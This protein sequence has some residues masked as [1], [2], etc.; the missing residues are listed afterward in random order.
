MEWDD[1]STN[2]IGY[3]SQIL[4]EFPTT[5][6]GQKAYLKWLVTTIKS[7]P[8]QK[9]IGFCYWAPDCVAFND[10]GDTSTNGSAWENQCMFEFNHKV[11]PIFDIFRHH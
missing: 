2:F 4:G 11:L 6:A 3:S 7:I 8:N 9:G 10:N 1:H 5:P